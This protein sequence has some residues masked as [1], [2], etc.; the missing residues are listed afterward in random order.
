MP[1][2]APPSPLYV[3]PPRRHGGPGN[4]PIDRVVVHCTAGAEPGVAG[5][6]RGIGRYFA[7]TDRFASAHYA[8]DSRESVQTA[9]DSLIC[10]HAPP[11]ERS[12]GYEL[13][14]SLAGEGRGH[15][16]TP[17][18]AAMLKLA[19]KDVARLCLANGVPAVKLTPAQLRAGKR[20][21]CGHNDVRDA[22]G[23]TSHWDPG[24]HFPWRHFM[25][26][27]HAEVKRLQAPDRPVK[28]PVP[29]RGRRV[30]RALDAIEG[31]IRANSA[32]EKR[33][34]RLH[35]AQESLEKINHRNPK[36]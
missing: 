19:A 1:K 34:R 5:A 24:P 9:Y 6:A 15:W 28:K 27:V 10:Y 30:D 22:W 12:I 2:I 35:N 3:G 7:N 23:Q 4:K 31:A 25:T 11:N 13:C 33:L 16:Q 17:D 18:H 14:C 8:C 20:G 26:L 32:K 36:K 29:T 21:I